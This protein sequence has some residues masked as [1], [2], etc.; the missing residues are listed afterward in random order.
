M[1]KRKAKKQVQRKIPKVRIAR[2]KGRPFQ[3]R[4]DCP[5]EKRQVR[6]STGCRDEAEAKRQ[7]T[8]LEAK[9]LLGL[10]TQPT[11]DFSKLGPEM[12]W[13]DFRGQFRT[14]HLTTVRD[15]TASDT[16]SRLDIAERILK[17]RTLGDFADPSSLQ[18]LQAKLLAGEQSRRGKPRSVHTVKGYMNC[19][20]A[21]VNW[22]H[23]Q[24]WIPTAPKI[25]KIKTP[26]MK[27]MKGRPISENEFN[28]MLTKTSEVVGEEAS[29]S[30]QYLLRGLWSSALRLDELMHISW[31]QFVMIR[32]LWNA[33]KYPILEIPASMQKNNTEENIPLL[34]WFENIL[35]ETPK[36]ERTGWVLIHFHFN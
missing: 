27:V 5:V 12:E 26:K 6:I 4:Y 32:P 20:L 9:L 11:K 7:K 1:A 15:N 8:E 31:D 28:E 35:F 21:A 33:G 18:R 34:P 14:L 13:E 36:D 2:P 19:I 16:E 29:E 22:A 23:L 3:L 17:P 30:W 24:G 10:E 25:R